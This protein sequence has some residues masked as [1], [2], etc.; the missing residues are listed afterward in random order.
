M[1]NECFVNIGLSAEEL[2]TTDE[3]TALGEKGE[4]ILKMERSLTR[5][6]PDWDFRGLVAAEEPRRAERYDQVFA[7]IGITPEKSEQLKIHRGKIQRASPELTLAQ[8]QFEDSRAA[9]H[10]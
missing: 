6:F 3:I 1:L 2:K 9:T 4:Y 5:R 10:E 7:Q 8:Q